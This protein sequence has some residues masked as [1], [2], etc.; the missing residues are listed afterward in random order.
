MGRVDAVAKPA[1]TDSRAPVKLAGWLLAVALALA[2]GAIV[3]LGWKPLVTDR[4]PMAAS[5]E[6]GP[7]GGSVT[8]SIDFPGGPMDAVTIW[9]RRDSGPAAHLEVHLLPAQGGPPLRS[10]RLEAPLSAELQVV[11][12]T[13]AP[14]DL[15]EG[16]LALRVVPPERTSA[17]LY[18]GA[19][20]NDAYTGGQLIDHLGWAPVDV[21]LAFNMNGHAG[22]LT[23][24]RAQASR[25][26][27]YLGIGIAVAL[28]AGTVVGGGVWSSLDRLRF[29]R[30]AAVAVT[31]GTTA[32]MVIGLLHG[33][34]ALT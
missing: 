6:I 10:A 2:L 14:I 5:F 3:G 17:A 23:R 32:A 31:G 8:Q 21:D 1:K 25:S 9:A 22:A 15:P 19:T 29:G 27:L 7:L 24:L 30:L 20:G 4:N 11:S 34:A 33:P 16:P 18:V 13:F 12:S 26:P 28:L